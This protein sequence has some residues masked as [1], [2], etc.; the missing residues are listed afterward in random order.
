M[1]TIEILCYDNA[2]PA[3]PPIEDWIPENELEATLAKGEE[4]GFR[5]EVIGEVSWQRQLA[6]MEN[7]NGHSD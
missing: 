7:M 3:R 5:V 2:Q 1:R 6:H 4:Y